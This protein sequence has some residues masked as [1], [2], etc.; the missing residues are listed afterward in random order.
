MLVWTL[1]ASG[2]IT[3]RCVDGW[4]ML[5]QAPVKQPIDLAA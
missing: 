5:Y 2:Q 1:M 4:K 3:L